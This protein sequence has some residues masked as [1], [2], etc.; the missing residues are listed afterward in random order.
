MPGGSPDSAT[1]V[2]TGS[3]ELA[4]VTLNCPSFDSPRKFRSQQDTY[5]QL[6]NIRVTHLVGEEGIG[7]P[8]TN[9]EFL[10]SLQNTNFSADAWAS[11]M[12]WNPFQPGLSVVGGKFPT[13]PFRE[14]SVSDASTYGGLLLYKIQRSVGS[15]SGSYY[16]SPIIHKANVSGIEPGETCGYTIG[17][18]DD[19]STL[20][21][22]YSF[23]QPPAPGRMYPYKVGLVA[24]MGQ[25][26]ISE[27]N[28]QI[29]LDS[30]ESEEHS[31]VIIF[32]GDLAY[33][34]GFLPRW[35]SWS[36][37]M[38]P[39]MSKIQVITTAGNHEV[40]DGEHFVSYFARFP[41][42]F[43]ESGSTSQ[44]WYS[45]EVGPMHVVNLCSYA[46]TFNGSFQYDWLVADLA[47]VNRNKT[48]WL[49]ANFH[50]ERVVAPPPHPAP[51]HPPP[52]PKVQLEQGT[53]RTKSTRARPSPCVST[54]RSCST[55][56]A[57]T[58]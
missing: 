30:L 47:S 5:S 12:P 48:P 13:D 27:Q 15:V 33:A 8:T 20:G 38:Q 2:W 3:A 44:L 28:M 21:S 26:S 40:G 56:R 58:S 25:T 17:T 4:F 1:V 11:K 9:R 51:L 16:Q 45:K 50:C 19:S 14:P 7:E 57:S 31:P 34:D 24:D 35:D 46:A 53:T 39:L 23:R 22:T 29:L 54:W 42:P 6:M 41:Q 18:I 52:R 10:A 49:I 43:R 36:F 37:M 32:G 55:M